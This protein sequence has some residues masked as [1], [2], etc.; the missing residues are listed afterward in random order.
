MQ[1]HKRLLP[2]SARTQA[3]GAPRLVARPRAPW[4]HRVCAFTPE[5]VG[6]NNCLLVRM[7]SDAAAAKRDVVVV[8]A[9]AGGVAALLKLCAD[10]PE[11]FPAAVLVALHV[12]ANTSVLPM[13]LTSH[14]HIRAVHPEDGEAIERG[15]IYVAPPDRHMLV[16]N[17]TIRLNRGPKEHHTRPAIDP[18]FRSAALAYGPRLVGVVLTGRLDDGVA[19]LQ[20]IKDCGGTAV[21]QDP[22]D[23]EFPGMPRHAM[24]SVAVDRCVPLPALAQALVK[25]VAEPLQAPRMAETASVERL[26]LELAICAGA[27]DAMD[28]LDKIGRPS[29]LSCPDCNGVLWELDDIKPARYRCATGHAFSLHSLEEIH[30]IAT[31]DALWAAIR[32]L[33][34]REELLR[35]LTEHNRSVGA[36]AEALQNE[37]QADEAAAQAHVLHRMLDER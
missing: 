34:M 5:G 10:L 33:Q 14:G 31:E 15:T 11:A 6:S 19:G 4:L 21:V 1:R 2:G 8:G 28:K 30:A 7:N 36:Q 3:P 25:L 18:L 24:Q 35:R 16:A 32:A 12:G 9:S 23:A 20:A 22:A 26:A 13:L 27:E 29:A 17:G 37:R